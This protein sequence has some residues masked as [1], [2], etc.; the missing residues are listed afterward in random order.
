MGHLCGAAADVERRTCEAL[1]TQC[2]KAD[3][4]ADDVDDSV[5][6]SDLV[7]VNFFKRCVVHVCFGFAKLLKNGGGALRTGG[8]KGDF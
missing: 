4:G 3:A 8:A 1:D 7:K 2:V 5:D 6:G